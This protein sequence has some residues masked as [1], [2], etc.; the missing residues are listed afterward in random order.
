MS[1]LSCGF[2]Y[3]ETGEVEM[4]DPQTGETK[5]KKRTRYVGQLDL[6]GEGFHLSGPISIIQTVKATDRSP[7]W[8]VLLRGADGKYRPIGTGWSAKMKA[9]GEYL[10]LYLYRPGMP[11]SAA[12]RAWPAEK[13]GDAP[14]EALGY[15]ELKVHLPGGAPAAP[16]GRGGVA[17]EDRAP[18]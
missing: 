14:A 10:S 4:T 17:A 12:I 8:S 13:P 18:W 5:K 9:G 6:E 1:N 11:R 3:L 16:G 15:Y 2:V 7:D